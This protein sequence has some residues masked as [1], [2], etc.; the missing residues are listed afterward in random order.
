LL[1]DHGRFFAIMISDLPWALDTIASKPE[2]DKVRQG[3]ERQ[4][5]ERRGLEGRAQ[6]RH[7]LI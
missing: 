5:L 4:G 3:L 2:H 6:D 7:C 1:V